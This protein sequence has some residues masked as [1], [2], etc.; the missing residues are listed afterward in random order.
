MFW[1]TASPRPCPSG[2]VVKKG[3]NS[4]RQLRVRDPGPVVGDADRDL[5]AAEQVGRGAP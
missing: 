4:S 2:L 5:V 1:L 3:L